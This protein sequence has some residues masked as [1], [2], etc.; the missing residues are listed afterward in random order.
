MTCSDPDAMTPGIGT[1]IGT[2]HLRSPS[3]LMQPPGMRLGSCHE[4]RA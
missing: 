4:E 1:V 3:G 2:G